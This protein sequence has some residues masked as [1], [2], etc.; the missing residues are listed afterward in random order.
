MSWVA[1]VT[2]ARRPSSVDAADV[3]AMHAAA[4]KAR[5]AMTRYL[6]A[7]LTNLREAVTPS[8]VN[9]A[10][11]SV[12]PLLY[13]EQWLRGKLPALT[14]ITKANVPDLTQIQMSIMSETGDLWVAGSAEKIAAISMQT[15]TE[16]T[17]SSFNQ[18]D[19]FTVSAAER[20]AAS[21]VRGIRRGVYEQINEAIVQSARGNLTR[22]QT[23]QVIRGSIGMS[24]PQTRAYTRLSTIA[25]RARGGLE[26][27]TPNERGIFHR[28]TQY[29]L[30]GSTPLRPSMAPQEIARMLGQYERRAVAH[31]ADT[32]ARTETMRAANTGKL[33][34]HRQ[35][36][37]DIPG[38]TII[39]YWTTTF[40]D[41]T[42]DICAP[43]DGQT[44]SVDEQFVSSERGKPGQKRR[45]G[46]QL[47]AELPPIHPR[48][49]CVVGTT[50]EFA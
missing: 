9:A 5:P 42:C 25:Q 14:P 18:I 1:T 16:F 6:V 39:K 23:V 33:E 40:D 20:D 22:Q 3:V 44:I 35:W 32:I 24:R 47:V 34:G 2:K 13:F 46:E 49:R 11:D 7:V 4:D 38:V 28:A 27:L 17:A 19:R 50:T 41:R 15:G 48:C 45:P 26:A 12:S 36:A 29:R 37:R 10:L 30:L 21:M 8:V 31:R 43:L